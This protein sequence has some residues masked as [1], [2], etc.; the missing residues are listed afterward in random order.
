MSVHLVGNVP[1]EGLWF[2]KHK[3]TQSNC[4]CVGEGLGGKKGRGGRCP[5]KVKT[6]RIPFLTGF[7]LE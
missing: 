6:T 3:I 5:Q 2:F 7:S 4:V 1:E